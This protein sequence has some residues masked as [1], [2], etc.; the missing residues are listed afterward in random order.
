MR[1]LAPLL[2]VAALLAGCGT[3]G[4]RATLWVT[5]D[6]GKHVLLVKQVP[7][8]LSV[9]QALERET[10]VTTRYGGRFI[11]SIDGIA[12]SLSSRHDWFW[13]VNGIEGDRSA[14]EYRLHPGEI[15]WWDYRDWGKTGEQ[16]PVV[17]G[18]FPE[19]FL[20]GYGGKVRPAVVL[21]PRTA[22]VRR[23]A[24]LVH[25]VRILSGSHP[26]VPPG[27]NTLTIVPSAAA[28]RFFARSSGGAGGPVGFVYLGDP[29]RLLDDPSLYR[30]RY[31]VP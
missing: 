26:R 14:T 6:T 25:A 31:R 11:E 9:A 21:G 28:P 7:A 12:G 23:L 8:G 17:V 18:A 13:F 16:V 22:T 15:A 27:V 20:H 1:R 3:G 24:R 4:G 10:K 5:T 2:A 29:R 30:H 19:P